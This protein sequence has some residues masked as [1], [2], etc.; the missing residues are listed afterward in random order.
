VKKSKK[1][2]V[3]QRSGGA[4][5][6]EHYLSGV[7]RTVRWVPD[8]LSREAR[9]QGL[10]G[11]STGLFG[12]HQTVLPTV[13]CYRPQRSAHVARAPDMSDVHR[14]VRCARR[15]KQQLFC[16]T[17]IIEGGYLRRLFIPL[18]PAIW[19]CGGPKKHIKTYCR[20]FQVLIHLSA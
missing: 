2:A 8:S 9:N 13:N 10:S 6:S 4:P 16:P 18:Q 19:M 11:L 12:A 15:Q 1:R 20:H 17:T 7:H 5:D 14:T 3:S